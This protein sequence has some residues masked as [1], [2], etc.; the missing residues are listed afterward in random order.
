ME[1]KICPAFEVDPVEALQ[2][3]NSL[4]DGLAKHG[5]LFLSD[6]PFRPSSCGQESK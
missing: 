5:I 4:A 3:A 1:R 2:D 6:Q